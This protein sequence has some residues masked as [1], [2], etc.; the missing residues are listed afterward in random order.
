VGLRQNG[1]KVYGFE[2]LPSGDVYIGPDVGDP[3]GK[4]KLLKVRLKK[5]IDVEV[6]ANGS[7]IDVNLFE[8]E[9]VSD[10]PLCRKS[11]VKSQLW[12]Y[13]SVTQD[14]AY[15]VGEIADGDYEGFGYYFFDSGFY[16]G[17]FKN[18]RFHGE[19]IYQSFLGFKYTGTFE[20]DLFSG[21]GRYSSADGGEFVGGFKNDRRHGKGEFSKGNGESLVGFWN[22]GVLQRKKDFLTRA[23]L[24]RYKV[25]QK[26]SVL[27]I[28]TVLKKHGL[29]SGKADGI[30]GAQTKTALKK[31]AKDIDLR[32]D[33]SQLTET[34]DLDA[35]VVLADLSQSLLDKTGSCISTES[36]WS[37]C[38]SV[39]SLQQDEKIIP[40]SPTLLPE[41]TDDNFHYG[42]HQHFELDSRD[43][44]FKIWDQ[45]V[46]MDAAEESYNSRALALLAWI[47]EFPS[48]LQRAAISEISPQKFD[49]N[50]PYLGFIDRKMLWTRTKTE[51]K[52]IFP[53][54]GHQDLYSFRFWISSSVCGDERTA[55]EHYSVRN[56]MIEA[57]SV[58]VIGF[59]LPQTYLVKNSTC[60]VITSLN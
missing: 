21:R 34:I 32:R 8:G 22:N 20:G 16:T 18:G 15:Y 55:K 6:D 25:Q 41:K 58:G 43:R 39:A 4:G 35:K 13:S 3:I 26:S 48:E 56:I 42:S 51:Y 12:C 36:N 60:F 19:G 38:F 52:L 17:E 37:A 23:D 14:S 44:S 24:D 31:L 40:S 9:K 7:L 30:I 29:L 2:I 28:Q 47:E 45:L 27:E 1:S 49:E 50:S 11:G 59:E 5:I 33:D 10:L 54:P 57:G 46:R 53:N